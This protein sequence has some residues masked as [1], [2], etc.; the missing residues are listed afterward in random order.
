MCASWGEKGK[1]KGC[2]EGKRRKEGKVLTVEG[3]GGGWGET[4]EKEKHAVP[5]AAVQLGGCL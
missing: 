2:R 1:R 3:G 4:Q 5:G